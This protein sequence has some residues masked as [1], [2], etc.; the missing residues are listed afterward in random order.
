MIRTMGKVFLDSRQFTTDPKI[1]REWK[2][3]RSRLLGIM[4][5]TTQ[6]D[7]GRFAKDMRLTLTSGGN[8]INQAFKAYVDG[9][10]T[11][12]R[13]T[14]AYR[15]YTGA[16]GTVVIVDFDAQPTFIR[17]GSG[18]LFEYTLVLDIATLTK[19]DFAIYNGP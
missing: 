2:P 3:R 15:D 11:V 16:E 7:F 12:R 10:M 6:Q 5:S 18:V 14:Y 1:Q 9:L 19:L 4:G 8:F 13:A 17:D